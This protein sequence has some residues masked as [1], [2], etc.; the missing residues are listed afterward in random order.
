MSKIDAQLWTR[1]KDVSTIIIIPAMIWIVSA[2][3]Q[4]KTDQHK[5]NTNID[6]ISSV[7]IKLSE[8]NKKDTDVSVQ[9]AKLETSLTIISKDL[10]EIKKML[11]DLSK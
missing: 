7:E 11:I 4:F 5:I 9:I 2:I 6:K 8:L 1:A 10:D 3:V